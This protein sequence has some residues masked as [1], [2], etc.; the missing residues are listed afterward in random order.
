MQC[1]SCLDGA[2]PAGIPI[3]CRVTL[4]RKTFVKGEF[5]LGRFSELVGWTAVAG[6]CFNT[7]CLG[8]GSFLA[9]SMTSKMWVAVRR[10]RQ[11]RHLVCLTSILDMRGQASSVRETTVTAGWVVPC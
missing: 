8:S 1:L 7:V 10:S 4:S 2:G 6:I 3:A 11:D 9:A 5:H